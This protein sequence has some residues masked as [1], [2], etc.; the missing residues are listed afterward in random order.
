MPGSDTEPDTMLRL[1]RLA[2]AATLI[3]ETISWCRGRREAPAMQLFVTSSVSI[4]QQWCQAAI[5]TPL[6]QPTPTLA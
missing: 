4:R 2:A 5:I 3:R 6:R 1:A